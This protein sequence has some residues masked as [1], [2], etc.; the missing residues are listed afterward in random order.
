MNGI[1]TKTDLLLT[2][3][4][5]GAV[6]EGMSVPEPIEGITRLEKLLFLLKKEG[7]F[8]R[9]APPEV[10]FN[11]LPFRMGPWAAEVYDEVDFLESLG[12]VEKSVEG[13]GDPSDEAHDMELFSEALIGKYQRKD[14]PAPSGTERFS[15]TEA[16]LAKAREIWATLPD[17]E[18]DTIIDIRRRFGRMNLRQLL[19]Y[20]YNKYPEYTAESEIKGTLGLE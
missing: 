19:R 14:L 20:V 6:S 5:G 11:F 15:L 7:G 16:G 1:S 12:L 13:A 3:L 18:K 9:S 10:D 2:L 4:L 8:L 17:A